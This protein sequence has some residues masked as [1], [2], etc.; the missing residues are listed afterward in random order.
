MLLS[1][2][3]EILWEITTFIRMKGRVA[4]H[5]KYC[6]PGKLNCNAGWDNLHA[7]IFINASR[8]ADRKTKGWFE[9]IDSSKHRFQLLTVRKHYNY[10]RFKTERGCWI[11][12]WTGWII[13]RFLRAYRLILLKKIISCQRVE[14]LALWQS[15]R[16]SWLSWLQ[17]C[18]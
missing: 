15:S 11:N 16:L 13:L 5:L 2:I 7:I 10:F 8:L 4:S 18:P 3:R 1:S 17:C 12:R 9:S 6:I 14:S